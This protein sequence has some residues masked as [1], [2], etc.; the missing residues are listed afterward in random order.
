MTNWTTEIY[1]NYT[2]LVAAIENID[3]LLSINITPIMKD[4]RQQYILSIGAVGISEID[5]GGA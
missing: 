2:D 3:N 5:G 1:D 4:N